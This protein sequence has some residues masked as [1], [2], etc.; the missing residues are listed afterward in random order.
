[1]TLITQVLA[2]IAMIIFFL[3]QMAVLPLQYLIRGKIIE[4]GKED[5]HAENDQERS[6]G[7]S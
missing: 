1:M 6:G 2:A 4:S 3:F 7:S 5:V